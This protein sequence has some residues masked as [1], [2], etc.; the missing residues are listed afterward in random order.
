MTPP[1]RELDVRVAKV[2][3]WTNIHLD[4]YGN[5]VG[6]MDWQQ[7]IPFYSTSDPVALELFKATEELKCIFK[8][9]KASG[10]K[11]MYT[12]RNPAEDK[13]AWEQ[14]ADGQTIAHA[15][16]LAFLEVREGK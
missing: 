9:S 5:W 8:V 2:L 14:F 11:Y 1:G 13:Q 16:C 10:G 12:Y 15:V 7:D 6:R 4:S 3:G